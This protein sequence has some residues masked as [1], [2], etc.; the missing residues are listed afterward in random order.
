MSDSDLGMVTSPAASVLATCTGTMEDEQEKSSLD[1]S[2]DMNL[3]NGPNPWLP[4]YGFQLQHH[5]R[6]QSTHEDLRVKDAVPVQQVDFLETIFEETSDDLQSDSDHSGT[7]YWLGSDSETESVIH[8]ERKENI[9]GER[10]NDNDAEFNS[11]IPKK[12]CRRNNNTDERDPYVT[13]DDFPTSPRSSRSSGSSRSSSLLQFESLER[14][15]AT[16]SPSSYSFDSLEYSYHSNVSHLGNTSPDSLEQDNDAV[17]QN[18]FSNSVDHFPRIRPY[19]SFDSLNICQKATDFEEV[20]SFNEHVSSY[21]KRKLNFARFERNELRSRNFWYEEEEEEEEEEEYEDDGDD[22]EFEEDERLLNPNRRGCGYFEDRLHAFGDSSCNYATSLDYKNTIDLR[23]IGVESRRDMF[24]DLKSGQKV[25][26]SSTRLLQ[27]SLNITSS[28]AHGHSKMN[29]EHDA[30]HPR[31]HHRQQQQQQRFGHEHLH[32]QR[33]HQQYQRQRWTEEECFNFR[34]TEKS[35]SAPSL[36][37]IVNEYAHDPDILAELVSSRSKSFVSTS[38]LFENYTKV[39][40]VPIDLDLCGISTSTREEDERSCDDMSMKDHKMAEVKSVR[41]LEDMLNH[42]DGELLGSN[43]KENDIETT[44]RRSCSVRTQ[45][46]QN[47]RIDV[48]A[49][50]NDLST[51]DVQNGEEENVDADSDEYEEQQQIASTVKTQDRS[52]VLDIAMAMENDIDAVVDEAVKRL[53]REVEEGGGGNDIVDAIRRQ[54]S[55]KQMSQ[56]VKKNASY[57]LAQ[58]FEVDERNFRRR[59][60][61]SVSNDESTRSPR[62]A[63]RKKRVINNASYELAQQYDYIKSFQASRG[64]F[65]R[66]DACDELE[67]SSSGRSSRL[68]VSDSRS[69]RTGS[70]S[71]L[72]L[73]GD[74]RADFAPSLGSYSKSTENVSKHAEE[75]LF[76]QIKKNSAF[77]SVH[78]E[79]VNNRVFVDD[80]VDYP[81]L[82]SKPIG[83]L[84]LLDTTL[85]E[86]DL[87]SE[88][89]DKD[90]TFRDLLEETMLLQS[91][92]S[93][94]DD[95]LRETPREVKLQK[96]RSFIGE[97]YPEKSNLS[98]RSRENEDL[99]SEERENRDENLT[100]S[101]VDEEDGKKEQQV[102]SEVSGRNTTKKM[103]DIAEKVDATME[104][105]NKKKEA[106]V[107]V[108]QAWGQTLHGDRTSPPSGNKADSLKV[109]QGSGSQSTMAVA[110]PVD[111]NHRGDRDGQREETTWS[112]ITTAAITKTTE[113]MTLPAKVDDLTS[114]SKTMESASKSDSKLWKNTAVERS[115]TINTKQPTVLKNE[116]RKKGGIGC[117]LQRFSKLRFSGRSKVPRSEIQNKCEAR[118]G[119]HS[120]RNE[121]YQERTKKEPDYII[122][123]LHPPDEER[124]KDEVVA[125]ESRSDDTGRNNVDLQRSASSVSSG[126]RAPVCSSKPPLPPQPPRLVSSGCRISGAAASSSSTTSAPSSSSSSSLLSSSAVSR[127]RAVTDLGNPAAIE[128]AKARAMQAAQQE[129]RPVGLLETDLDDEVVLTTNVVDSSGCSNAGNSNKKTRSLLDLNHTSSVVPQGTSLENALRVPQLPVGSCHRNQRNDGTASGID[130]RPHKSMEFLL[131]KENLH[132]VKPPENELQKVGERVP[133]EH[134]LRVQRSLQRLNVPDWYKN[135]PTARDGF[136]LKRHS[137]ASQHG[138]WRALGSKTTSLSSLSSSSNRQPTTGALLSPSPTPPVFSRWSTSLLNSAGSSPASSAKLSFYHRQPYLGWR[139]QERL[140]N[141]RTPAERLAQ[142]ILSQLQSPNKQQQQ[143]QHQN[144]QHQHQQQQ[145]TQQPHHQQQTTNQQLEVRNSIKEVTSAIVHYVQS[146]QEVDGNERLS[147]LPR[148]EDWEDRG[149]VRSTSPRGSAR[150]CWMESSFVG[151]RPVDSPETP[152][153]LATDTECCVGCN[154]TGTESCSCMDSATSGLYLDVTPPLDDEQPQMHGS[155]RGSLC[156]SPSSSSANYNHPQIYQ[157]RQHQQQQQ[158]HHRESVRS[159]LELQGS[160]EDQRGSCD[161]VKLTRRKSDGSDLI[162]SKTA[163]V[164]LQSKSAGQQRRRRVS[165]DNAQQER[166]GLTTNATDKIVHCRNN[167]CTNSATLLEARRSYKSCHNCTCLYCSREC[168]RAHWQRHR[169]ICLHSRAGS[170]CKEVLSS[171]KEDPRTLRHISALAKRGYASHGRGAVKCFFSSPEAAERFVGNGFPELGEPTY[172]RWSDLLPG[173]MGAE[174]YAEVMRLCKSYNPDTR[175]VLYVAICV[176]SEV[177]TSGAVKWER[178]LV[179]RCAKLRLDSAFRQPNFSTS[180]QGKTTSPCNITREMDSPETLV[181]TSLPTS[182]NVGQNASRR[183]R[184]IGF[185]NIQ[186][187]LRLRGV[188][189]KKHFPQVYRKLCSYVDGSVDKFAPVTIYPRDQTSGKSFMCIIMLDAEPERLRLLP[190]DSSRVKTVD[191][192]VEQE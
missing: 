191:I 172:I 120:N 110:L 71:A 68:K 30:R 150:L 133:S 20:T 124:S 16:L 167:K 122:I 34:F 22:E 157:Q 75:S 186:K 121:F 147:P 59:A 112:K 135:S 111:T 94:C 27:T 37:S 184:E 25:A 168:R 63:S 55:N 165:F 73:S 119:Q 2:I 53:K 70:S 183:V 10:I 42:E 58:Q 57:E 156:L 153:S 148:P 93:L 18:G 131:D 13:F 19:R 99:L 118:I 174:L 187:Q 64:A 161:A 15:C 141:P 88:Q 79:N 35:Q 67:E 149:E 152:M 81:C 190:T 108:E 177:P 98:V 100:D 192:S 40:S 116:E 21:P 181:L 45:P 3:V 123:P 91:I 130:Q 105:R 44:K 14:T 185:T 104:G 170:L 176:V 96:K 46:A 36:P 47:A 65:Q 51:T 52:N 78:G 38:N 6:F 89:I 171:A 61:P 23:K 126:R 43:E 69:T 140:S 48:G 29:S 60:I 72:N 137:D 86:E 142:G 56:K 39:T 12:R 92:A 80:E 54:Y 95:D 50:H 82:E 66:M 139:S 97:F 164:S 109:S 158:R 31:H 102:G 32:E 132:F 62:N 146:G 180:P 17:V 189:L 163:S 7:T 166:N 101:G 77:F 85:E 76:G 49:M 9:T 144:Q 4:A 113:S 24:L 114:T 5:S 41:G 106:E 155:V 175:L 134:E 1:G 83:K 178:Q 11:I 115:A 173:E 127:R 90:R 74:S 28:T 26:S 125:L 103:V 107:V 188:S 160:Y 138:G 145:Q 87:N 117:F 8:I 154:A 143:Q 169:R 162:S 179:S 33:Q 182:T 129:Q 84:N 151:T 128:M 159:T 136:R